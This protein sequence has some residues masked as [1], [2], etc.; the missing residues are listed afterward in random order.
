MSGLSVSQ[1]HKQ[2]DNVGL[3]IKKVFLLV[4]ANW[5]QQTTTTGDDQ[6]MLS[7]NL[8]SVKMFIP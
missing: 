8:G 2:S 3:V 6:A 7:L 5:S 4:T 1:R